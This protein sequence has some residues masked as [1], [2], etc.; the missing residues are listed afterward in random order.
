M[1]PRKPAK[2]KVSPSKKYGGSFNAFSHKNVETPVVN[3]FLKR[4]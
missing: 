1:K 3:L 2:K 4:K